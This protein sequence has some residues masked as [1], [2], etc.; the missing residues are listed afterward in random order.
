MLESTV[1]IIA[2]PL[3]YMTILSLIV[4]MF[5][6]IS[7][8]NANVLPLYKKVDSSQVSNYTDH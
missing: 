2:K 3:L 7:L 6:Y 1:L 8:E 5:I 4:R